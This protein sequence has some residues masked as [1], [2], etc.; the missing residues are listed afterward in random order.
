MENIK[1]EKVNFNEIINWYAKRFEGKPRQEIEQQ[2]LFAYQHPLVY[3]LDKE[4]CI[5]QEKIL[6][7]YA[8]FRLTWTT[9]DNEEYLIDTVKIQL[10]PLLNKI[11]KGV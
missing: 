9:S 3:E 5:Q 11:K 1:Q 8:D 2:A 4:M 10:T 7:K 6:E